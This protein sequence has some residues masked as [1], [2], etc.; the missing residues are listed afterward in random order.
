[1]YCDVRNE[2]N[3][4]VKRDKLALDRVARRDC[5]PTGNGKRSVK[6]SGVYRSAVTLCIYLDISVGLKLKISL[7][8]KA[9]RI[10]VSRRDHKRR[11][12]F[13][14]QFECYQRRKISRN[15]ILAPRRQIPFVRL[16]QLLKAVRD[17]HILQI[18]Y[19][20]IA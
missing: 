2:H 7:Q 1:M 3:V 10:A 14:R 6:P 12:T 9:R 4:F 18:I 8:L 11:R 15:E 17:K 19:R 13:S 16:A 20:V 5:E